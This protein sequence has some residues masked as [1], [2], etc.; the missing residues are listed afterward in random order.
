MRIMSLK[1]GA[2]EI[3]R[4]CSDERTGEE[5]IEISSPKGYLQISCSK[6]GTLLIYDRDRKEWLE[7]NS[8]CSICGA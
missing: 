3:S 1:I 4:F 5:V 6:D 2:A 7:I 8:N